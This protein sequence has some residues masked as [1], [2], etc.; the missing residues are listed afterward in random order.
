MPEGDGCTCSY[1]DSEEMTRH[2]PLCALVAATRFVN[3][4]LASLE[5]YLLLSRSQPPE[6]M[7]PSD[8]V[9]NDVFLAQGWDLFVEHNLMG[10]C[11][12]IGAKHVAKNRDPRALEMAPQAYCEAAIHGCPGSYTLVQQASYV[13]AGLPNGTVV[14]VKHRTCPSGAI[15]PRSSLG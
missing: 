5:D 6:K 1:H 12:R 13:E 9:M 2:A 11:V 3:R 8:A 7:G 4:V 14:I 10:L 15:L